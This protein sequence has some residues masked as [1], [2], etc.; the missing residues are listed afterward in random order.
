MLP[1]LPVYVGYF[2]GGDEKNVLPRALCFVAGFSVTFCA[3]GVFAG[4]LGA[5]LGQHKTLVNIVSG[6][7]VV[8]LGLSYLDVIHINL[9]NGSRKRV[10]VDGPVTAFLFGLVYSVSLTPCVGAFLG[11]AIMLAS[12]SGSA[13][14]GLG[15]LA[16]YCLGLGLPFVLAAVLLDKLKSAFAFIKRHY[17]VIN[18]VC[19]LFLIIV[20]LL[21]MTGL[22]GRVISAV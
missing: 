21:M 13:L 12:E 4:T 17:A 22:L 1:M 11:S 8:A 7:V 19:G 2:A 20:G 14:M 6:L 5:L 10:T 15:L 9:F 18:R 3:L 16:V